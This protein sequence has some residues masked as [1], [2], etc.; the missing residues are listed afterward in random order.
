MNFKKFYVDGFGPFRNYQEFEFKPNSVTLITGRNGRGKSSF[1]IEAPCFFWYNKPYKDLKVEDW[2]N[3]DRQDCEVGFILEDGGV[4]SKRRSKLGQT[5]IT[6]YGEPA[7]QAHLENFINLDKDLFFN[8]VIFP[9]GFGGFVFLKDTD[10][11]KFIMKL[12]LGFLDKYL[13]SIRETGDEYKSKIEELET[14]IEKCSHYS[15]YLNLDDLRENFKQYNDK[16][17]TLL[18]QSDKEKKEIEKRLLQIDK[19]LLSKNNEVNKL[20]KELAL[21]D[22]K[23]SDISN[24]ISLAQDESL[25]Y[26]E[27]IGNVRLNIKDLESHLQ[28]VNSYNNCPTCFQ[29]IKKETKEKIRKDLNEKINANKWIIKSN[30][31]AISLLERKE[32]ELTSKIQAL[33]KTQNPIIDT[34]NKLRGE[35]EILGKEGFV[36]EVRLD[37]IDKEVLKSAEEGN[38]YAKLYKETQAKEIRLKT[39]I[40]MYQQ[41]LNRFMDYYQVGVE[42][43]NEKFHKLRNDVFND[44]LESFGPLSNDYFQY[45]SEGKYSIRFLTDLKFTK[46]NILDKFEIEVLKGGKKVGFGRLSPGEQ[47]QLALS[48]NIAL[49]QLLSMFIG[50]SNI[51]V[52]DEIFDNLDQQAK[53]YVFVLLDK[54]REST[55]KSLNIITHDQYIVDSSFKADEVEVVNDEYTSYFI[56]KKRY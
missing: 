28:T 26:R 15:S 47:R 52:M 55:G 35:I 43:W 4:L 49:V 51:L 25:T 20:E 10:K 56:E 33:Y 34:C 53:D 48:N 45:I 27:R 16:I 41:K 37:A 12:S 44:L 19:Q 23:V 46:K 18:K 3:E 11:K 54:L 1:F 7:T 50:G 40:K 42:H 13:D 6:M 39:E 9:Q 8:S 5:N 32:K 24:Q 38:P 14:K 29:Y 17:Q 36:L 22:D 31:A 21:I 2:I 30:E